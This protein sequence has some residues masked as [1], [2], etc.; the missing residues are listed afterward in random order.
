MKTELI[1]SK[2]YFPLSSFLTSTQSIYDPGW[3]PYRVASYVV[4]KP[5]WWALQQLS[6][7][8]DDDSAHVSNAQRWSK[9]KGDYVVRSL[10]E[11]AGDAVLRAQEANTGLSLAST[12]YNFETFKREFADGAFEGV[13][14]SDRDMKVLLK[15]LERDKQTIVVQNDVRLFQRVVFLRL[16]LYHR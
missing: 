16:T 3:L 14:L 10:L 6:I 5:L 4:G 9:V 7:V 2:A 15:F 1:S 11:Q 13:V 12:L 8:G